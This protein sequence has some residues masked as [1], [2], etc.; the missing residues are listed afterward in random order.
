V[1]LYT[2]ARLRRILEAT[3]Y[4]EFADYGWGGK[5]LGGARNVRGG[6]ACA[7]GRHSPTGSRSASRKSPLGKPDPTFAD[8][9]RELPPDLTEEER[10]RARYRLRVIASD[11]SEGPML[12]L[13]DDIEDYQDE[14]GRPLTADSLPI[15]RAVRMSMSF[16]Y[17]FEPV[18]LHRNGRLT[19]ARPGMRRQSSSSAPSVAK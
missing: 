13:P 1:T 2:P 19:S 17:F 3:D 14:E 5:Y 18:T 4:A 6:V 10:A 9:Q 15:A 16:P 11:I 7:R 8:V 12:V